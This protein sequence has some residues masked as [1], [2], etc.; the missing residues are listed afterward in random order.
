MPVSRFGRVLAPLLLAVAACA[1]PERPA[2]AGVD[3]FGDSIRVHPPA[4]RVVSLI[5]AT[6]EIFFAIGGGDRLVGRTHW[7]RWPDSASLVP[8]LGDGIRPNVEA[9]LAARPDL[10]VLY[11]SEDNRAA[12]ARLREAGV[13]TLALRVDSIAEFRR[14]ARLL[15]RIAG[16]SA[17]GE[18]V[19]DSVD[20]TLARVRA[21]TS[22]RPRATVFLRSWKTPLLTIGGGSFLTE[23]LDIAGADNVYGDESSPSPQ[24]TLEDVMRR[25]PDIVLASP[26]GRADILADPTWR[27]LRAVR[28]G[29]VLA[30]DQE[31]VARPGVRLGEAAIALARLLHP[32][33]E[34]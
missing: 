2:G 17:R 28:E 11:A 14:V 25:D 18:S 16:D 26:E 10:V 34:P 5:P 15:G 8:D 23:L 29:R 3:D 13:R 6:T 31:L 30:L 1:P 7:D 32:E 12:A 27:G 19:V 4:R 33:L 21:A 22:G 24:V 9:V 20:A